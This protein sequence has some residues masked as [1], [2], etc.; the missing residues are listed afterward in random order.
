MPRH[1]KQDRLDARKERIQENKEK[2]TCSAKPS[3]SSYSSSSS[4]ST[5]PDELDLEQKQVLKNQLSKLE[6]TL[7]QSQAELAKWITK[8]ESNNG[9]LNFNSKKKHFV[10]P[11]STMWNNQYKTKKAVITKYIAEV[12]KCKKL[13]DPTYKTEKELRALPFN[14]LFYLFDCKEKAE[15]TF[16]FKIERKT[17]GWIVGYDAEFDDVANIRCYHSNLKTGEFSSC[18][19]VHNKDRTYTLCPE[20]L[21]LL[22]QKKLKIVESELASQ[23]DMIDTQHN[24]I[25][26][27]SQFGRLALAN[28]I[29]HADKISSFIQEQNAKC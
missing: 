8:L 7:A 26:P 28:G 5:S 27:H 18:K 24:M 25:N 16:E 4:S 10:G 13:L 9:G 21:E 15:D 29:D 3:N 14:G 19:C 11:D 17:V 23:R 2:K 22:N 6:A 20:D 12:D 1:S